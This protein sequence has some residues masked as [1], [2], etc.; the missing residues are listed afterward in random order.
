MAK[1]RAENGNAPVGASARRALADLARRIRSLREHHGIT[2][3]E[4][5]ARSGISVSFASLLER[6]QRSPSYE[7][8]IEVA[9]ALEVSLADLLQDRPVSPDD[10]PYFRKLVELARRLRLSR[11]QVDRWLRVGEALFD[12]Q[13]ESP[14]PPRARRSRAGKRLCEEEGCDKLVLA[15][16]LCTAHY[17]RARR[18]GR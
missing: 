8:L 4:L 2:Q 11:S 17:H 10:D 18:A 14:R 3:E 7:T 9:R 13:A 12:A 6:A 15:R 16:G 1:M 5:A